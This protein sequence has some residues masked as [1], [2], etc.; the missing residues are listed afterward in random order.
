MAQCT[1]TLTLNLNKKNKKDLNGHPLTTVVQARKKNNEKKKTIKHGLP[2]GTKQRTS[3]ERKRFKKNCFK[4]F[5][6][7]YM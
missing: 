2:T 4:N 3:S 6:M 1:R 7:H 5:R